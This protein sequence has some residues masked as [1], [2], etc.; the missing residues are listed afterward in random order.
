MRNLSFQVRNFSSPIEE[1]RELIR[2]IGGKRPIKQAINHAK[3]QLGCDWSHSRARKIWYALA[4]RIYSEEM[5]R[6]REV[7]CRE[8]RHSARQQAIDSVVDLRRL[9]AAAGE[10]RNARQIADCDEALRSLGAEVRP[11][12]D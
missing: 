9:L 6:L 8:A 5:D 12:E 11:V 7:A 3:Q 2:A 4:P 10:G 1:A